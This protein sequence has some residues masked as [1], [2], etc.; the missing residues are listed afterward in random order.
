[1]DRSVLVGFGGVCGLNPKKF[2]GFG[3]VVELSL[4]AISSALGKVNFLGVL[5]ANCSQ[6]GNYFGE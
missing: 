6:A 3:W 2:P 1:M 5:D 4:G